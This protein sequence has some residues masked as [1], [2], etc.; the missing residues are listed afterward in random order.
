MKLFLRSLA[1]ALAL[2]VLAGPPAVQAGDKHKDKHKNE[3]N[4]EVRALRE[5]LQHT[6]AMENHVH[7]ML[8]ASGA[9]RE[10]QAIVNHISAEMN[11]V[12]DELNTGYVPV[13]HMR[14]ELEHIHEELHQAEEMIHARDA[15]HAQEDRRD[16]DDRRG[17]YNIRIR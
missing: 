14:A 6:R 16:Y 3:D 9:N 12:D 5:E 11:H 10:I 8:N 4:S 17:G 13:D 7:D 2:A 15:R 1:V